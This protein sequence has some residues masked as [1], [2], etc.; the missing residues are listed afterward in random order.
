VK[1]FLRWRTLLTVIGAVAVGALGSGLWDLIFKPVFVGLGTLI[2][3]VTT[4]GI[5]SIQDALYVQMAKG[6]H[7]RISQVSAVVICGTAIGGSFAFVVVFIRYLKYR[8][9]REIRSYNLHEAD[10]ITKSGGERSSRDVKKLMFRGSGGLLV[11]ASLLSGQL[12]V[13]VVR[14]AY[15]ES[16]SIYLDQS[17]RVIAPFLTVDERVKLASRIAQMSSKADFEALRQDFTKI[18]AGRDKTSQKIG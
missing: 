15:I 4:L 9:A 14:E 3:D 10:R 1:S 8:I 18:A 6:P 5:K 7:D 17:L 2:L 13:L 11:L 12:L 16:G